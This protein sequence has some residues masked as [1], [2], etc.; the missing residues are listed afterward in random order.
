MTPKGDFAWA[1][2]RNNAGFNRIYTVFDKTQA[3]GFHGVRDTDRAAGVLDN[4]GRKALA[5]SIL[6]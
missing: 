4:H 5:L 1:A 6:G 2:L 3:G